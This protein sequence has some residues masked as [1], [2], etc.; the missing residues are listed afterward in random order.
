MTMKAR[1]ITA[2]TLAM[3]AN[4][5]AAAAQ[6]GKEPTLQPRLVDVPGR[7]PVYVQPVV[8]DDPHA[9]PRSVN[10][11]GIGEVYV[12][13]VRPKDTRTA[14]QRCIESEVARLNG[15]ASKLD[16][17]SIDLKCSQR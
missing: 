8:T 2:L 15:K 17:A 11:Q 16:E 4:L 3:A 12:V 14:R 9:L 7:G 6:S 10:V 5:P 13:P 1:G